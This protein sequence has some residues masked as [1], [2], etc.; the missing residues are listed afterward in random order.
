MTPTP[1][2]LAAWIGCL[3][4]LVGGINQ[5][6]KV[7]DRLKE[8]P[9][10]ADTY[11]LR[12]DYISRQE[13]QAAQMANN[14]RFTKIDESIDELKRTVDDD[15]T[16]AL[17]QAEARSQRLEAKLYETQGETKRDI[18]GLHERITSVFGEVKELIGEQRR[19]Q[20]AQENLLLHKIDCPLVGLG[21]TK[22]PD[23]CKRAD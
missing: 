1:I 7:L 15:K 10:P 13:S 5:V 19:A 2:E 8:K 12:G 18:N 23:N 4:F 14:Q 17:A 22:H 9:V 20:S 16:V 3:F 6:L 21:L 11:Q